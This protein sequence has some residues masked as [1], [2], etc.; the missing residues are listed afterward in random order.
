[1]ERIYLASPSQV[2]A[3]D[4]TSTPPASL[5]DTPALTHM[6]GQDIATASGWH[7]PVADTAQPAAVPAVDGVTPVLHDS[8]TSTDT[9]ANAARGA[10]LLGVGCLDTHSGASNWPGVKTP[11]GAHLSPADLTEQDYTGNAGTAMQQELSCNWSVISVSK[12]QAPCG[13]VPPCT[14]SASL[15]LLPAVQ[16]EHAAVSVDAWSSVSAD[17]NIL[18]KRASRPAEH[19]TLLEMRVALL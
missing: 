6:A 15:L 13:C 14:P 3:A 17:N 4:P 19:S 2:L 16:H 11:A 1:M 12:H 5:R 8:L 18:V 9:M 7:D 10:G